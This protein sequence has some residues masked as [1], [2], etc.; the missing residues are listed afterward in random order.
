MPDLTA[1]M[2][3]LAD[4]GA[5][6]GET[7]MT[8][9]MQR[10]A[11]QVAAILLATRLGGGVFH[12]WLKLPSVLGELLSGMLIGPFVLGK[13]P[14][15]GFGPLFP[16]P[17][18]GELSVSPELYALATLGSLLL[19]FLSGLE[20]DLGAFLRYSVA[21]TA[22]G[23]GGVIASFSLGAACGVWFGLT[24]SFFSPAA[25]FLGAVSTATSVGITA[26]ILTEKRKTDSPEGVTILA[27]AVLDDV[28]GIVVLAMV[29]AL[30]GAAH[31]H[32]SV[33]W[34]HM[35]VLLARTV[36]FWLVAMFGGILAGPWLTRRLKRSIGSRDAIASVCLGLA[37][38][39]SGLMESAGLAMIIGAYI[40]GLS[41]SRTDISHLVQH[42]LRGAYQLLVP[43]FFCVMGMLIDV[44]A[45]RGV[46]LAG[47][48]YSLLAV[49]AKLF[50][51]GLPA[52]FMKFNLRGALRIG[53]GMVPRGEVALIVAGVG[54]SSGAI[55]HDIFGVA[56][57]MTF[58]TTL[59]APGLLIRS[60][61]G[62]SGLR[63]PEP[64]R[65]DQQTILLELQTHDLAEFFLP[66]VIRAF[67]TEGFY[68][69]PIQQEPLTYQLRKDDQVFSL[70]MSVTTIIA[71]VPTRH[72]DFVRLMLLEEML[73]LRE[74]V[75][76]V[77]QTRTEDTLAQNLAENLF[78]D[79]QGG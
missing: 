7:D 10:L 71:T 1:T 39:L 46:V 79:E 60:F 31:R 33:A 45:M 48:A 20:T 68:A 41:L 61:E 13:L 2:T 67:E 11:L 74:A 72:L 32:E 5:S 9:L 42:Q 12:R 18:G 65:D 6:G 54:L 64:D 53:A 8:G 21:G 4:A 78:S 43:V 58:L 76:A 15:P 30:A 16:L 75:A 56:V 77:S 40:M 50:G 3:F 51:C 57:M 28:L 52:L 35:A 26:R 69:Y 44:T 70:A 24:P 62:P 38:L 27:G 66:R 25:L 36:V 14:L 49:F 29:V 22:V 19:L 55:G 73:S 37:L 47:L 63:V 23:I 34:R 17:A 59:L